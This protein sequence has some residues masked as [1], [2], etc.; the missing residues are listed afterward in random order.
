MTEQP[1]GDWSNSIAAVILAA[2]AGSRMGNRP[3]CLL[4]LNG[5]SLIQRQISALSAAGMDEIHVVL[6]HY[7]EQIV[8]ELHG[9]PVNMVINPK[10]DDGQ[11]SSLKLGL[12][13]LPT[14]VDA[15]LVALA[16]QPLIC[17]Q[18]IKDLIAAF[19]GRGE[20][21]HVVQ[22]K[23]YGQPGNPVIFTSLVGQAIV[24]GDDRFGCKQWQAAHPHAVL[25]W[26]TTNP[27]Y[28]TDLDSEQDIQDLAQRT[29]QRF[30]WR[31]DYT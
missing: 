3:K 13:N 10:P 11:N 21:I 27:H 22:P 19:R 24:R 23:V 25:R 30:C 4:E 28:V 7:S 20:N 18:D 9:L 31:D 26:E 14:H 5:V 2:G 29:G 15:V 16:D 1:Q 17:A 8:L 12:Q 6:G